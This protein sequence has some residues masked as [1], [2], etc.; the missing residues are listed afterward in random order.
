MDHNVL[1][2]IAVILICTKALG[3]ASGRI[4]MPQVVGAL[5]AGILLGP[6][7]FGLVQETEFLHTASGIG[8][9][10]LMFLAGLETDLR[11][12]KQ[13]GISMIL[14][15]CIGV[16]VPFFMGSGLYILFYGNGGSPDLLL[17]AGFVGVVLTATSV[18]ITVEA[19]REM[20]KAQGPVFSAILGAAILDDIL[21]IVLLTVMSSFADSSVSLGQT[22]GNIGLFFLFL[23]AVTAVIWKFYRHFPFNEIKHRTTIFS[24]AFCLLMAYLTQT[25][26][27]VA[28]ITGAYAA[29]LILTHCR[30][31]DYVAGKVDVISYALFAP[32][33]FAY[34]G[35]QTDL[36]SIGSN[37]I[38]F[39]VLLTLAA[40]ISKLVGCGLGARISGFNTRDS[41]SIG[42]GMMCRGEVALI[43]A[44]KGMEAGLVSTEVL[45]AAVLMVIV[46][47]IA[48][49]IFL[50]LQM[51]SSAEGIASM[52]ENESPST[53]ADAAA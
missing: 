30:G 29:V 33:F 41:V 17:E 14:I 13:C 27:G 51:Q 35:I 23:L 34:I 15:A 8:V 10:I 9:I 22:M 46:T 53:S 36:S 21:G 24:L 11:E 31:K 44:Q 20:G 2:W 12:L 5:F 3:L 18:S 19:L 25:L 52:T 16:I 38:L 40:L 6:T 28:D 4:H 1:L 47:T 49:P 7:C 37:M 26:F 42:L 45:S 32:I 48:S 50:R 43:V 39:A